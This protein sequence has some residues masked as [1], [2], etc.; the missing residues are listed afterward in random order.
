VKVRADGTLSSDD[1]KGSIHQ[2]GAQLEGAPSCNGWTYWQFKREGQRVPIDLL[3]Q[4]VR[5]EMAKHA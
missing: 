2:V 3:R 5:A 1:I 4:Q